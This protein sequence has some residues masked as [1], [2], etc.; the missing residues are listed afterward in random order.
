MIA[1]SKM[2]QRVRGHRVRQLGSGGNQPFKPMPPTDQLRCLIQGRAIASRV[3]Q[4][5]TKRL[6]GAQGVLHRCLCV[7]DFGIAELIGI[8]TCPAHN[9]VVGLDDRVRKRRTSWRLAPRNWPGFTPPRYVDF[10]VRTKL[11]HLFSKLCSNEAADG[12]R[13]TE[14]DTN[15][16]P[17]YLN[18]QSRRA[19]PRRLRA[20][21]RVRMTSMS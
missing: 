11:I 19:K 8:L 10:G 21:R 15:N 6:E 9:P 4:G 13:M 5:S 18:V 3:E 12:S 17:G 20:S 1:L 16:R 7:R 14:R 2:S